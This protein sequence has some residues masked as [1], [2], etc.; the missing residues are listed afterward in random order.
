MEL[1]GKRKFLLLFQE[2]NRNEIPQ[3]RPEFLDRNV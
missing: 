2:E 1:C 3:T